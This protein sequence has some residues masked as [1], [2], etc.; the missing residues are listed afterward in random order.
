MELSEG[1]WMRCCTDL[2]ACEVCSDAL[3]SHPACIRK[4]SAKVGLIRVCEGGPTN[5]TVN[6]T[7]LLREQTVCAREAPAQRL[8][9]FKP[10]GATR[11]TAHSHGRS[12]TGG[13]L[14]D[15]PQPPCS[16]KPRYTA[17]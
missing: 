17:V 3:T 9:A 4:S 13:A 14:P 12:A 1:E 8:S 2:T 15:P 16:V 7:Q 5:L 6:P 11:F 10:P